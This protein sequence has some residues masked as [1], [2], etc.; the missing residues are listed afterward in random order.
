MLT[1]PSCQ[2][3]TRQVKHGRNPSGSQR[4]LCQ[5]CQRTYT[6]TPTPY[7]YD[8]ATRRQALRLY[9]DGMN[10]R[11]IARH[12]GVVHQTVANW[13]AAHADTLP[14]QPPQPDGPVEVAELDE[15]Y[16]FI[17]HK[18]RL[19]HRD[20]SGPYHALH[21]ELG[22]GRGAHLGGAAGDD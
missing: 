22:R 21:P 1:C 10:L 16:T 17:G 7:G 20:S 4:Y 2:S 14:E 19:L 18:K 9:A 8:A 12:L 3:T 6:P 5:A 13:V 15:L 11:R